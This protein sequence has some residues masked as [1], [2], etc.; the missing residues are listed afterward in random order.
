MYIIK[1]VVRAERR[2]KS[3]KRAASIKTYRSPRQ[4]TS[5]PPAARPPPGRPPPRLPGKP[6]PCLADTVLDLPT[7]P[8]RASLD[9]H[10]Y[11]LTWN[12]VAYAFAGKDRPPSASFI[13]ISLGDVSKHNCTGLGNSAFKLES[14]FCCFIYQSPL[15]LIN[16]FLNFLESNENSARESQSGCKVK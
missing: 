4:I 3:I 7:S 14:S 2:G 6:S 10:S 12:W 5:R 16:E 11:R 9:K 8:G 13:I 15:F 1:G